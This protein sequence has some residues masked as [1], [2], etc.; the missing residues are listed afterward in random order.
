MQP[1]GGPQYQTP[2]MS[3]T[4]GPTPGPAGLPPQGMAYQPSPNMQYNT[5]MYNIF[6][7]H[8]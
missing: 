2:Y 7:I 8:L 1:P 3:Q 4:D 6:L 5:G